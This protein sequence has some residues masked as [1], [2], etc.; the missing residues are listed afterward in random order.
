MTKWICNPSTDPDKHRDPAPKS[1]LP[2]ITF[3]NTATVHING[4]DIRAVHFPHG[5]TDGDA[6]RDDVHVANP[7]VD[8][9]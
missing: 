3:N 1:A 6:E 5:H 4:E 2:V 9:C 8:P 7:T